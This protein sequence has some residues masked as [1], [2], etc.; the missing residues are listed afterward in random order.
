MTCRR[1]AVVYRSCANVAETAS[2]DS[3]MLVPIFKV[4]SIGSTVTGG[5][6]RDLAL[7]LATRLM[8]DLRNISKL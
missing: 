3:D 7:D 6:S 8:L 5:V 2:V 1:C 4:A